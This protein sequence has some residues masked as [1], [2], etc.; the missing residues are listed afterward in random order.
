MALKSHYF[1]NV[2]S[3][4]QQG[5][6]L[7]DLGSRIGKRKERLLMMSSLQN[8]VTGNKGCNPFLT[9]ALTTKYGQ[10]DHKETPIQL[11]LT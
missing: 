2:I 4:F 9:R 7:P 6:K 3:S 8:Y 10:H 11:K 5:L 1:K